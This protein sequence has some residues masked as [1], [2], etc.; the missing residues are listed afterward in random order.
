[1]AYRSP[2]ML[3]AL[4]ALGA[5]EQPTA[6]VVKDVELLSDAAIASFAELISESSDVHLVRQSV[7]VMEATSR[8]DVTSEPPTA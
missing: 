6:P 8:L 5:C 2:V 1:M 3:M 7:P 4:V